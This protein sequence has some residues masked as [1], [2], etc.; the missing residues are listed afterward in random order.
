MIADFA[1]R[2]QAINSEAEDCVDKNQSILKT[3]FASTDHYDDAVA[4]TLR[5]KALANEAR[6]NA[7]CADTGAKK[8]MELDALAKVHGLS[9]EDFS[10]T[11][12]Q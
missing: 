9:R 12:A 3:S 1:A 5:A 7:A 8:L 10:P 4:A 2:A 6:E 11:A